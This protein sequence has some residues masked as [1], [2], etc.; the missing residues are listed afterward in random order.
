MARGRRGPFPRH[1]LTL[2]L[3]LERSSA[4]LV[5]LFCAVAAAVRCTRRWGWDG[6][7]AKINEKKEEEKKSLGSSGI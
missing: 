6:K 4:S 7:E 3:L 5:P 1:F 2:I